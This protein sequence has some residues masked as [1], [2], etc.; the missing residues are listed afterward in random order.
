MTAFSY[1][2]KHYELDLFRPDVDFTNRQFRDL[3]WFQ[4]Q[5]EMNPDWRV[6]LS[7]ILNRSWGYVGDP[8]V[9]AYQ[10][11]TPTGE[12]LPYSR[13]SNQISFDATRDLG[14]DRWVEL[15]TEYLSDSW[16]RTGLT[17][18]INYQQ[19]FFD[20][21]LSLRVRSHNRNKASFYYNDAPLG[22]PEL[23][24]DPE[25]SSFEENVLGVTLSWPILDNWLS[26]SVASVNFSVDYRR[27]NHSD[28][29][30]PD[31]CSVGAGGDLS[32]CTLVKIEN[33]SGQIYFNLAY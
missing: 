2:L 31:Q 10:L 9:L 29:T 19:P 11:G 6:S 27:R 25:N 21:R 32:R 18:A 17:F 22:V 12:R 28:L 30:N 1:G 33:T 8:Y 23:T 3:Y 26:E 24:R 4:L 16:G 20:G 5:Q 7:Y 15:S 14:G 13:T